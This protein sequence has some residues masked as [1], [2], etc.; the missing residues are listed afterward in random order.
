LVA[1]GPTGPEQLLL[2]EAINR[3]TPFTLRLSC[4]PCSRSSQAYRCPGPYLQ[5][6]RKL[7]ASD[8]SSVLLA[9]CRPPDAHHRSESS[10][11]V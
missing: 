8:V 2:G 6:L 11:S 10:P 9:A 5:C 4:S 1:F 7:A 3:V